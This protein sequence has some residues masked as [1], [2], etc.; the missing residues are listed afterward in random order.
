MTPSLE[1]VAKIADDAADAERAVAEHARSL[2][3]QRERGLSWSTIVKRDD[4][5]SIFDLVRHGA[6]LSVHALSA[7]S[8]LVAE[9]L[10]DE[11]ASRRQIAKA[12]GVTHQRVSAILGRA[13]AQDEED[14]SEPDDDQ[15]ASSNR[16]DTTVASS[17]G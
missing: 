14:E 13:R 4:E 17:D 12:M 15:P 3:K 6:R 9:Q 11:G 8:S 10:S 7:L 1:H 16:T 5:P 2:Q